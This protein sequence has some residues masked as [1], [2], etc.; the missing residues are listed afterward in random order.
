MCMCL[1]FSLNLLFFLPDIM[2]SKSNPDILKMAAAAAK[3]S[4]RTLRSKV[5]FLSMLKS[6]PHPAIVLIKRFLLKGPLSRPL[7]L[8]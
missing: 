1:W 6:L 4:E 7:C 3:R 8:Q 2:K 5:G